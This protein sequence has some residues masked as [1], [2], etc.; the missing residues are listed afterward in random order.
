MKIL[1]GMDER[2]TTLLYQFILVNRGHQVKITETG[3]KC[4]NT[5]RKNLQVVRPKDFK[6]S[7]MSPYDVV[8][9]DQVLP[10]MNGLE[11]AKRI[12]AVNPYQRIILTSGSIQEAISSAMKEL[13]MPIQ[14]LSK[15]LLSQLLVEIYDE[16]KKFKTDYS[17]YIK[18]NEIHE[19]IS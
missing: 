1:V 13:R 7:F 9:L 18:Y 10:D 11:I 19:N 3:G 17:R 15:A 12:L 4:I 16:L 5:Y 2:E 14:I 8:I 6:N